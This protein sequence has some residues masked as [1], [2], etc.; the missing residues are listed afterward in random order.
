MGRVKVWNGS[1]WNDVIRPKVCKTNG[2]FSPIPGIF[3]WNGSQWISMLET[4]EEVTYSFNSIEWANWKIMRRSGNGVWDRTGTGK[5]K[6]GTNPW[7]NRFEH[8]YW[9]FDLN[10]IKSKLSGLQTIVSA[11]LYVYRNSNG[12]TN[13]PVPLHFYGTPDTPSYCTGG[14]RPRLGTDFGYTSEKV[15]WGEGKYVTVPNG[16]IQELYNGNSNAIAI[17]DGEKEGNYGS[18]DRSATLKITVRRIRY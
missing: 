5:P 15:S 3:Y 7:S 14:N 6:Q 2:S 11:H 16:L 4:V 9:F 18:Y 8:G 13:V 12:G 10:D 17:C 1:Q